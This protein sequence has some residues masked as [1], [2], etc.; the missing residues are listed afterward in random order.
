MPPPMESP[1][2]VQKQGLVERAN[3]SKHP[4]CQEESEKL[5]APKSGASNK[6]EAS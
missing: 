2:R 3:R 4:R 6:E 1:K 5:E